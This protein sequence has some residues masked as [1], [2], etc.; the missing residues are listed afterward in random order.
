MR[1]MNKNI[2][3]LYFLGVVAIVLALFSLFKHDNVTPVDTTEVIAKEI[4]LKEENGIIKW[5]YSTDSNWNNLYD[6]SNLKGA[7][8]K[9]GLDGINGKDGKNG[10]NGKDGEVGAT[11]AQG[12]QGEQGLKGDKG[13]TGATGAQGPQGEQG[14][15]G[16]KGDTGATGAQGPQGEQGPKGD[17]GDTGATG[18]QGPQGEQGP[19]GDKGDTGETGAQG[20]QGEQGPKGDKGDTGATGAQGPQGEQGPKG[21][22]GDTG[23]TGAQGPAGS[24]G[25][26]IELRVDGTV[27][28]WKYTDSNTWT[29]LIDLL[30][31]YDNNNDNTSIVAS[32]DGDTTDLGCYIKGVS[33]DVGALFSV[34]VN[35]STTLDFYVVD[36]DEDTITLISASNIGNSEHNTVAWYS[37]S[38]GNVNYGPVTVLSILNSLTADWTNISPIKNYTYTNTGEGY[39][40]VKINDGK[41][42]ITDFED[43]T[44]EL[45]GLARARLLTYDEAYSLGC[46]VT[47]NASNCPAWLY[48]NLSSQY[49]SMTPYGYWLLTTYSSNSRVYNI[50]NT[51]V[52]AYNSA[53]DATG[54]GI[55]PVITIKKIQP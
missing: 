4:N 23:A 33:C 55:R 28:Q 46:R 16:D 13:D 53:N 15:K 14:L 43:N 12:L 49:N 35:D 10:V 5:K 40:K 19:K 24:N 47:A 21:D 26:E 31:I 3:V 52:L 11:G 45:S 20:P 37:A 44:T 38:S 30:T 27:I 1:S 34:K 22:K 29:D 42:V 2:I 36:S 9:D 39:K 48:A 17:K 18:P 6:L 51:G 8:G 54:R 41:A 50:R 25:R 32:V 7:D